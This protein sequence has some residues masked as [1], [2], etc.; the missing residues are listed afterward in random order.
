M[1]MKLKPSLEVRSVGAE[2]CSIMGHTIN[3]G[4]S[5]GGLLSSWCLDLEGNGDPPPHGDNEGDRLGRMH[6][7][8]LSSA[9][10][11]SEMRVNFLS[12][13]LVLHGQNFGGLTNPESC[14]ELPLEAARRLVPA[15]AAGLCRV[16]TQLLARLGPRSGPSFEAGAGESCPGG[17][18]GPASLCPMSPAAGLGAA[19]LGTPGHKSPALPC[20]A[21]RGG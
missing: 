20:R 8:T 17:L 15:G 2:S 11:G 4:L 12:H 9:P 10:G 21:L 14:Q 5:Q 7:E 18:W 6:S 13:H 16:R 1:Y 19:E 3:D